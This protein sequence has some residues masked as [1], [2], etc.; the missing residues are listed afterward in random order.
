MTSQSLVKG[1]D[2]VQKYDYSFGQVDLA[3]GTVDVSKNNGQLGKI[4]SYIGTQKQWS[5]RFGYDEL[6]RLSEAAEYRGD[7]NS[8]TYKQKFDFDR[9]GNLYRKNS[10]NPA[11]GQTNPL[12]F[13]PIE[14]A[15]ISK[16]T[17]RFSTGTV[18]DEAGQ[19]ITDDKFRNINFAYDA[20]GRQV[21]AS[22]ANVPDAL[23]VYDALGNRVATKIYDVWQ[24]MVYDA[25]GKLVAEYGIQSEG[26]GG[27][28]YIQQD[29]QGSV[30]TVTNNSG[31]IVARTDHQA[32][33]EE[34]Q[35]GIG[36]RTTT[37]GF[38]GSANTRQG[39]GLT[40]R[41][42]ASGKQHTGW[43]KLETK[44]G[45]WSSP[46]PY[47]ASMNYGN[48]QSFNR[49]SYVG[50][51]PIGFVD[52]SGLD[53]LSDAFGLAKELVSSD[54]CK[55]L[56]NGKDPSKELDKAKKR[57]ILSNK[58]PYKY[59]A[60]GGLLYKPIPSNIN[61]YIVTLKTGRY[62]YFNSTD[63]NG[64]FDQEI[65]DS[66]SG[67]F[68]S[69]STLTAI[70]VIH[71]TLHLAGASL[72]FI[73]NDGPPKNLKNSDKNNILVYLRCFLINPRWQNRNIVVETTPGIVG[74]DIIPRDPIAFGGGYPSWWFSLQA[75][76]ADIASIEVGGGQVFIVG[77]CTGSDCPPNR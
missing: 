44:A 26:L 63:I 36:L 39:Y 17:N 43:R 67:I 12:P 13:T 11:T 16:A 4:E 20:N 7:N 49:Y 32:F 58:Y 62:V 40:E 23:T 37:Q 59:N 72:P 55:S 71:E 77:Y 9:F 76:L 35:S 73:Q 22:K 31:I 21:K 19:V 56:F 50:N 6:G 1:T 64:T 28:K 5:Q 45:R 61:A 38:G 47:V 60:R 27:V 25:F 70:G 3:S 42:E 52:P 30:R 46:D 29:W 57:F 15:D 68:V 2:V 54:A 10:S 66:P 41:D 53:A 18:Y 74:G 48:P 8:L 51:N 75:F 65:T 24:Y 33:G 69:R 14:D 34:I